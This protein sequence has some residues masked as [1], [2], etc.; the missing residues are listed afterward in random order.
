M[1]RALTVKPMEQNLLLVKFDNGEIKVFN[2]LSLMDNELF[3][4][5]RDPAFFETVHVDDMGLVCWDDATDINP[6]MLY[7]DSES[8]S[9]ISF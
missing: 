8:L 7:D 3:S 9:S 1:H 6:D 4:K 5:L 2:C